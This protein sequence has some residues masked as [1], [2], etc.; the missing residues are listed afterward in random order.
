MTAPETPP[1]Q[2]VHGPTIYIGSTI[3]GAIVAAGGLAFL[4][5]TYT[6]VSAWTDG[7]AALL[8]L[9]GGWMVDRTPLISFAQAIASW[10]KAWRSHGDHE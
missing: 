8:I 5:L 4:F 6:Q 10:I 3:F 2:P 9:M 1:T 7:I